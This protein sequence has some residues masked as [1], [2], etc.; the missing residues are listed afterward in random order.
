MRPGFLFCG[1]FPGKNL[2]VFDA[3]FFLK[4]LRKFFQSFSRGFDCSA[5]HRR[6]KCAQDALGIQRL[7]HFFKVFFAYG[8]SQHHD[9][10]AH[11]RFLA[12]KNSSIC[13]Y[14]TKI[15]G[16]MQVLTP[17]RPYVTI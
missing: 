6:I 8:L 3:V 11:A 17:A 5:L 12:S 7:Q 10:L 9:D 16:I 15:F 4:R 1:M 2:Y 13:E 14:Y